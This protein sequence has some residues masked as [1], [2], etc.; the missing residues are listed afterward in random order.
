KPL[1]IRKIT[2][3]LN[4]SLGTAHHALLSLEQN[5][6]LSSYTQGRTKLYDLNVSHPAFDAFKLLNVLFLLNPLID[7]LKTISSRIILFGSY[8][9]GTFTSQSD[10][11]MFIIT[12][13]T[14]NVLVQIEQFAVRTKLSFRPVIRSE[15]NR[16]E[17]EK[18]DP[19]VFGQINR[20]FTLWDKSVGF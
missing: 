14:K 5:G 10:C 12:E 3:L 8:S 17:L 20:G 13:N 7:E 9:R 15:D 4:I 1:Y 18:E 2:R 11:E 6:V 16:K 19:F